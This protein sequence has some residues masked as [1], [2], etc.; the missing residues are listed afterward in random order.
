LAE[1]NR[2]GVFPG[3]SLGWRISKENFMGNIPLVNDLKLRA[4]WGTVGSVGALSNYAASAFLDS[5]PYAAGQSIY[6]G[7]TLSDAINREITW[8]TSDK[9]NIGIDAS[10]WNSHIYTNIDYYIEDTEGQLIQRTL[11]A[12]AGKASNPYINAGKVRNQG[13]EMLLGYAATRNDWNFDVNVNFSSNK[14]EVID[15]GGASFPTQGIVEGYPIRSYFGYTTNGVIQSQEALNANPQGPLFAN[16][17]P[18]DVML[19]DVSGSEN[20]ELT[21]TPDGQITAD[22]RWII[23][24]KYPKAIYGFMGSIGYKNLTLQVQLQGISGI[25]RNIGTSNDYGLFHYYYRWA[26]NHDAVILDRWHET[27]NPDGQWPRVDVKDVGKNKEMSDYWLRDASFLRI[28]NINLNYNLP[29]GIVDRLKMKSFGVYFTIQNLW[30]FTDFPGQEV[31][32][33]VDPMTGVP[34]PRTYSL[35][36]RA[37]F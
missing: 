37:T 19:V 9:K 15:L 13:I 26:L 33:T 5:Y 2:Y 20:G 1:G 17:K 23:G 27:K 14:N 4:S 16:K 34:Q 28:K 30:T 25:D 6:P 21:H 3:V 18:G 32:S 7:Y 12:S 22:D 31:D 11:P 10:L 36:L 24:R 29:N 35:G 8:E